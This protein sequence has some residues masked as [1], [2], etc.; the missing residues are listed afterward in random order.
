MAD[1]K[2]KIISRNLRINLEDGKL[3]ARIG[4]DPHKPALYCTPWGR[5]VVQEFGE[6]VKVYGFY[7][8]FGGFENR[9]IIDSSNRYSEVVFLE[10][11]SENTTNEKIDLLSKR[12]NSQ[13]F[14]RNPCYWAK[15]IC[16]KKTREVIERFLKN[17]YNMAKKIEFY[18]LV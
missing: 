14:N 2:H 15:V 17:N 3:E 6:M 12:L 7:T 1:N 4:I 11:L 5:V 13:Q 18:D 8:G 10:D 16:N 9:F